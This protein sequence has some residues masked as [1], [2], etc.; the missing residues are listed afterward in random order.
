VAAFARD[1]EP[2]RQVWSSQAGYPGDPLYREF[3]RD[4]GWDLPHEY[5]APYIDPDGTRMFTGLKYYR[6]TDRKGSHREPYHP[7]WAHRRAD[8]H[9]GHFFD[10][11]VAEA[12]TLT[13]RYGRPP[14]IVAPFDA[15]LFG[16]WWFE[17]PWFIE[18]LLRKLAFDQDV[19]AAMS[20]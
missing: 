13:A 7:G 9:A 20:P 6:V 3:Y 5:V 1:L 18:L 11:R 2:S 19:I 4:V 10:S 15:E 8:D 16:H 14:V 12:R 17:G